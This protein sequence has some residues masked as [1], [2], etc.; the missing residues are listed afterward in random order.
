MDD[1]RNS[2]FHRA[3]VQI[4]QSD[5]LN[6]QSAGSFQACAADLDLG[7]DAGKDSG[8]GTAFLAGMMGNLLG[9]SL[10]KTGNYLGGVIGHYNVTGLKATSY[11]SG[12]LLAGIG[13]GVTE[14]DGAVVAYVDGDSALTKAGAAFKVRSNNSTP[15]SGF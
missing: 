10:S 12:A 2:H 1:R 7:A 3:S 11:P 14:A 15:G 9:D 4:N 5:A 8:D 13:D 6:Y